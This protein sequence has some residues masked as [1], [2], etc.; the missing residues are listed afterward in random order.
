MKIEDFK[1]KNTLNIPEDYFETLHSKIV[2]KSC[3]SKTTATPKKKRVLGWKS[4]G[5]AASIAIVVFIGGFIYNS[6]S[7][8]SHEIVAN[9]EFYDKD[10]IENMLNNYPIDDYTFYCYLTNTNMN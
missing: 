7:G 3:N 6:N 9:E 10:Y 2:S 1:N 4:I 8:N 5:Y